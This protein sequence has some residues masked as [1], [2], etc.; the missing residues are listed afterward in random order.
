VKEEHGDNP[1]VTVAEVDLSNTL[2]PREG[3][4][5]FLG[6]CGHNSQEPRV[7][8]VSADHSL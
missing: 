7:F 5:I 6:T 4:D 2:V 3:T 1:T 8:I